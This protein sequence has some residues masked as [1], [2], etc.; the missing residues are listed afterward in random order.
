MLIA[1][2]TMNVI[3]GS[4]KNS[5]VHNNYGE[6]NCYKACMCYSKYSKLCDFDL[7]EGEVEI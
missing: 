3:I 5:N 4:V 2:M 6:L 7:S 1:Y